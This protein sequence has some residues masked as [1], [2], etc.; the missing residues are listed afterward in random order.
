MAKIQTS[1]FA[2]L[3]PESL[4]TFAG[5][6]MIS[7]E[8]PMAQYGLNAT[9][10]FAGSWLSNFWSS[11]HVYFDVTN[12]YV[13]KKIQLITVPYIFRGEWQQEL[14]ADGFPGSPKYNQ[15]APDLYIPLMSFITFILLS[16]L[17]SGFSGNFSP[18][19]LGLTASSSIIFLCF[20]L[21][22]VYGGLYFLQCLL[23]SLLELLAYCGYKFV[24]CVAIAFCSILLGGAIYWPV[25]LYFSVC[26]A[27]FLV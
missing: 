11:L 25:F 17:K 1:P 4:P 18:Q 24:P 27:I 2:H 16:G 10:A 6:K 7:L 26:F 21:M 12:T 13:I 23:P 22:I 8:N 20:E 9:K 14:N 19:I 5:V 15:H 3:S